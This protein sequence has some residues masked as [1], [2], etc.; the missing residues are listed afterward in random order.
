MKTTVDTI[1]K[2]AFTDSVTTCD[3]CGRTELKGTYCVL[4]NDEEFY[5]G[6]SCANK[7]GFSKLE[8]KEALSHYE[9][10]FQRACGLCRRNLKNDRTHFNFIFNWCLENPLE[11]FDLNLIPQI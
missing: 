10:S 5:F 9:R 4:V 11:R 1:K 2:I 8:I 6:S 7:K 3:C